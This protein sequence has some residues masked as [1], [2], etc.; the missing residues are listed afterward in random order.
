MSKSSADSSSFLAFSALKIL[1]GCIRG[2]RSIKYRELVWDID[3]R[4]KMGENLLHICLLHNTVDHN[5]L[6]KLVVKRYPKMVNDIFISEEYYGLSPLH[7]AIVNE[8]V[9]MVYFMCKNNADVHQRCYGSFFCAE[10]QKSSRTDSLEHEWVDLVHST[11]Y[12]GQMYWGEYPLSFAAC[13]NQPDCFR[14][15]RT[16]KADPNRQ[17]TN[18]NTVLH[19]TVIH[20]LPEMFRLAHELG[21]K[22]H[23]KNNQK[24]TP[25]GVAAKLAKK[26]MFDLILH[27]EQD[28]IWTYGDVTC[29]AFPLQD[30]D[31]IDEI[32][33]HLNHTSAL[34]LIVY[35]KKSTHLDFFD[36][37]LED[38]LEEKW[39]V[40][41]RNRLIWSMTT[42]LFYLLSFYIA[43]MTR[44]CY[45][46]STIYENVW[47]KA[48]ASHTSLLPHFMAKSSYLSM[49]YEHEEI[50]ERCH[51]W[52]YKDRP[53]EYRQRFRLI[54]EFITLLF[55]IVQVVQEGVD[56]GHSGR[57]RWW[58]VTRSFP[59]KMLHKFSFTIVLMMFPIRYSCA[60]HENVVVVENTCAIIAVLATTFHLFFF[61]RGMKFVGPFVLMVYKIIIGDMLR[62]LL[63]YLIFLISFS[64]SCFMIFKSCERE[65]LELLRTKG[66]RS[67]FENIMGTPIEAIMRMF[68]MSVGNSALFIKTSTIVPA[69][70]CR[71]WPR[72]SS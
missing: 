27:L 70:L 28:I 62:F 24:L 55:A 71:F 48:N 68:L 35:G 59:A 37:L 47:I 46:D 66:I 72:S 44:N 65:Y 67:N 29:T 12:T 6:A 15:L 52:N 33:G 20:E 26:K 11:R 63:I 50:S 23:I 2:N 43:F 13:T 30:I 10:D 14:L 42:Y 38:L 41:A 45:S 51:L 61:C 58:K 49:N 8:D 64:Q 19:L 36:G 25:M 9:E 60:Y 56:I 7:Q 69:S 39:R 34:S 31:T 5:D 17:D 16:C 1:D 18:G 21:A 3:E 22:L 40:F 54:T 4:G 57:K 53:G 32:T